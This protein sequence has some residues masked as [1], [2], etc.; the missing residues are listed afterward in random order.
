MGR[1]LDPPGGWK[2]QEIRR[3][4]AA[5]ADLGVKV[6]A[7]LP[8]GTHL[9]WCTAHRCTGSPVH[10]ESATRLDGDPKI[11]ACCKWCQAPCQHGNAD[12]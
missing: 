4:L 7:V 10:C 9:Y 3:L 1:D 11:P 5:L 12:P 8:D 6:D 2:T